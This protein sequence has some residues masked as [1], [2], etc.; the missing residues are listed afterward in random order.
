MRIYQLKISYIPK[1]SFSW[2]LEGDTNQAKYQ[3]IVVDENGSLV[4]D[5][6]VVASEKRHNIPINATLKQYVTYSWN[7]TV[8]DENGESVSV[9]GE[10]FDIGK[11]EWKAK[12]IEPDRVRKKLTDSTTPI[13]GMTEQRNPFEV[14]DPA[15]DMR[16][17]FVLKE[18]PVGFDSS[19]LSIEASGNVTAE[20]IR[21]VAETGVDI[22]SLGALTHSVKCFDISMKIKKKEN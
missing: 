10:S 4:W 9:D 6:G 21:Q 19:T 14:L 18:V 17:V 22:I 7:L 3:I 11:T 8:T 16:K 15:I 1:V 13:H 20:N 2:K 5:S 12:W